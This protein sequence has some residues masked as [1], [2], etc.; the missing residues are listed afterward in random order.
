ML[1]A[2]IEIL[3]YTLPALIVFATVY[4]LLRSYLG[5]MYKLEVNKFHRDKSKEL[6]LLKLQAYERIALLCERISLEN[7][8][9]RIYHSDM[10]INE[11]KNA[12]LIAIQQEFE[13]NLTQQI[14]ISENLWGI[15]KIAKE[16]TQ[17]LISKS[18]GVTN[19]EFF[20]N[21]RLNM[22]ALNID[23]TQYAK[24]AI[25]SEVD[26]LLSH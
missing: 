20:N 3:K 24:Q 23:P 21:V 6:L 16:Q 15:I 26:I 22:A 13:H 14:Y 10:G 11:L 19:Q 9:F 17:D 7:L 4:F 1:A 2:F 8:Y 12:M 18:E 25:K 5:H